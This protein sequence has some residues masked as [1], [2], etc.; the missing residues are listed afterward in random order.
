MTPPRFATITLNAS[1]DTAATLPRLV[2]GEINRLASARPAAGGKGNNVARVLARLGH[3][4]VA[5]GFAGGHAGAFIADSL[6]ASGVTPAFMAVPGESRTCLTVVE[7]ET[8]RVTEIREPG[9]PV[10]ASDGDAFLASVAERIGAAERVAI[11][12]SLPPGLPADYYAKLI[13]I[14]HASGRRVVLD[15]SGEPLRLALAAHPDAIAPNRDELAD[16]VGPGG[17][18]DH[19]IAAASALVREH[20]GPKGCL[21]LTL[22]ASGA[23]LVETDRVLRATPPPVEIA[24]PVGAGDALLAGWLAGGDDPAGALRLAVA[25]GTAAAMQPGIGEVD[26]ADVARILP[27]VEVS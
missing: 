8:G 4:V 24:N 19:A 2:P 1:I 11:S 23:A 6:R 10:S 26:P 17:S 18:D 7:S 16:L 15:T 13:E 20:L 3:P 5:T 25:V 22:G 14:L 21:M 27:T 12:G 9:D